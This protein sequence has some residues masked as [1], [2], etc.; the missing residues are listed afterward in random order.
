MRVA[1][2]CRGLIVIVLDTLRADALAWIDTPA[3]AQLRARGQPLCARCGSFPTL[4][5]RTDLLTGH[6]AFLQRRW[7]HPLPDEPVLTCVL[8]A[9]GVR[10]ELVTDNYVMMLPSLGAEFG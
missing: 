10:T 7:A 2:R 6:L 3:V 5:M 4:P 1:G 9:A 8:A